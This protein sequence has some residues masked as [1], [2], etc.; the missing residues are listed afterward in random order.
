M[1]TVTRHRRLCG[2]SVAFASAVVSLAFGASAFAD[3]SKN[4][5]IP[6]TQQTKMIRKVCY[7]MTVASGIPQPCERFAGVPTTAS[8]IIIIGH[9][10]AK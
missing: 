2:W 9:E 7:V 6:A 3:A 1:T 4:V 5:V 8:P 10:T